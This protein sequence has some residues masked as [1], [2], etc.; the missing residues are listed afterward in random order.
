M[1]NEDQVNF[2]FILHPCQVNSP[3]RLPLPEVTGRVVDIAAGG[4]TCLVLTDQG[5]VR[6]IITFV[7]GSDTLNLKEF[8]LK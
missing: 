6:M 2:P 4:T 7:F 3:P 1:M 5:Q 8:L